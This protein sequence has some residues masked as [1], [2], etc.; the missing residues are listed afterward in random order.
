MNK[1]VRIA[2][3]HI[4]ELGEGP[5]WDPVRERLLWVDILR[6]LIF[7]GTVDDDGLITISETFDAG[8]TV[9][10][11]A[12]SQSGEWIIAGT[13]GLLVRAAEGGNLL[14][15]PRL[16]EGAHR[17]LNDGKPD[18][19]GRYLVGSVSTDQASFT[20]ELF[21]VDL[22]RTI[23][24]IDR[25]LSLSNGMGW[26]VSGTRFYSIDTER[27]ALFERSYDPRSGHTGTRHLL[28][29]FDAGLPDGMCVDADD[30]LWIAMWG[31]GQVRRY[32]S[33][34]KLDSVVEV[35]AP[36]TS[37]VAFAGKNLDVLIITTASAGLTPRQLE[38]NP[39]SGRIFSYRPET[40]GSPQSLWSPF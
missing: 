38:T 31:L 27:R 2:N 16:I 4:H 34:G 20:E 37:C 36:N 35:P 25:D 32:T 7:S 21:Q 17:R 13:R 24:V 23:R 39:D 28:V 12:I 19:A 14:R 9:G 5:F 10:A 30:F 22:D 40:P 6:N 11:V 29:E 18:P 8:E 15:G 3:P 33:E 26:S 1:P